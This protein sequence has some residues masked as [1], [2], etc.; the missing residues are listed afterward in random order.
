MAKPYVFITGTAKG[1]T[2]TVTELNTADGNLYSGRLSLE[3][4]VKQPVHIGTGQY[5]SMQIGNK[6][7]IA[8]E[9][10]RNGHGQVVIPGA[11]LK[12]TVKTIAQ[13]ASQSC[14]SG[15]ASNAACIIC[16]LFGAISNDSYRGKVFF[17]EFVA[18]TDVI[19]RTADI[20]ALFGPTKTEP[21]SYKYYL[22]SDR[23]ETGN[24]TV[25]TI[26][27]G[28]I[29]TGDV[30]FS[31]LREEELALLVYALG[32]DV[33]DKALRIGYG[34]PAYLG[35]VSV[36]LR[37]V[38]ERTAPFSPSVNRLNMEKIRQLAKDHYS[39][40]EKINPDGAKAL[41]RIAMR[42]EKGEPWDTDYRGMRQ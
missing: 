16:R 27:T 30:V 1:D 32:L 34:K 28:K 11:S 21:Q 6:T 7:V 20:P 5:R 9:Q 26:P 42:K 2:K 3:L 12:G 14:E 41:Q 22:A 18:K 33:D 24:V 4:T 31:S 17:D 29:F 38:T 39:H 40:F 36:T 35:E 15:C 19:T 8:K 13:I 37:R 25:E 10:V 23:I